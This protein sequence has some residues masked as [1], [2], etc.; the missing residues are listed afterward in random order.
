M[1][2]THKQLTQP[3]AT[4]TRHQIKREMRRRRLYQDDVGVRCGEHQT[5]V[6]RAINRDPR[7]PA[8]KA[9]RVFKA[10]DELFAE[11]PPRAWAGVA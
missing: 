9:A 11:H 5:N 8:A 1:N 3:A 6:S 4:M 7:I 10:L 2:T